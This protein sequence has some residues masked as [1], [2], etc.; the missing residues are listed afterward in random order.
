MHAVLSFLLLAS[1]FLLS[2][3]PE[4]NR[5]EI[6]RETGPLLALGVGVLAW[7]A[8]RPFKEHF[9]PTSMP[10]LL[11]LLG[12]MA[13]TTLSFFTAEVQSFGFAEVF[14]LWIALLIY[15]PISQEK[16]T[17][18]ALTWALALTLVA[19]V[20]IG[21]HAYL[22]T[23]HT[24]FFGF[25]YDAHIKADAWP[26]AFADFCLLTFPFFVLAFSKRR[27]FFKLVLT[28]FV[29]SGFVLSASRGSFIVL[30]PTLAFF[31][32]AH[33]Y[34][35]RRLPRLRSAGALLLTFLLAG[36]F[37]KGLIFFKNQDFEAVDLGDRLTFTETEGGN[38]MTERLQFF[39]GAL[40][41]IAEHPWLGTGP[42]SFR[43][44]YQPLQQGFLALSDHA[45]NLWLKYASE[46]GLP[47]ALFFLSFIVFL[48]W[49][50]HPFQKKPDESHALRLAAWTALVAFFGHQMVDYNLNFITNAL[51]FWFILALLAA[52]L[53]RQKTLLAPLTVAVLALAVSGTGLNL[54]SD[55]LTFNRLQSLEE[56]QSF[57]PLLPSYE[58]YEKVGSVAPELKVAVL[59][60]QLEENPLDSAAWLLLGETYEAESNLEKARSAYESAIAA[61]PKNTFDSYLHF[62]RVL[63]LQNDAAALQ[64]LAVQVSPYFEEYQA[65]YDKNLHYTRSTSEMDRM[66][67][68]QTLLP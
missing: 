63:T 12:F 34:S 2:F 26:N 60:K 29:L 65:L 57:D 22:V 49:K 4:T 5:Y 54:V 39:E 27:S 25:F 59:L 20:L 46:R 51:I 50:T 14:M 41:L 38:S 3:Y 58:W 17:G 53:P 10:A 44:T 11:L 1:P 66:K 64:A 23:D 36:V 68:L 9:K 24:R 15:L 40:T 30:P 7:L 8:L 67:E 52:Q 32:L 62:A 31:A 19:S 37:V 35:H 45:H 13:S 21:V 55:E 16:S 61:N 48:F 28:A 42:T 56:I 43:F 33:F 47:A 18:K 6:I